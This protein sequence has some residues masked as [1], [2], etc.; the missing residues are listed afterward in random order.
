[1]GLFRDQPAAQSATEQ[2]VNIAENAGIT[3]SQ[4]ALAWCQQVPGVT[5]TIIG[6]TT[7]KQLS[8]NIAAFD[9]KLSDNTLNDINNVFKAYPM[10]F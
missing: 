10:G 1:M 8:E 5:S 9:I 7:L 2:Y 6:A 3:P 4:L